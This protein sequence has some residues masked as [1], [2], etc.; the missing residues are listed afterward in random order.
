MTNPPDRPETAA[1]LER[2]L[3]WSLAAGCVAVLVVA[4]MDFGWRIMSASTS[5]SASRIDRVSVWKYERIDRDLPFFP[6][7]L[8][9][10]AAH[11]P[12]SGVDALELHTD[13]PY[14][15]PLVRFFHRRARRL[16]R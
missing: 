15:V 6:T 5:F 16:A 7:A 10:S 8:R 14:D 13:R 11:I 9:Y 2:A 4:A 12:P 1:R 3:W